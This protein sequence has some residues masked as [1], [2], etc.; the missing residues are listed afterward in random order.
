VT[1]QS[2]GKILVGGAFTS[3]NG[4]T[5]NRLVRLNSDGTLDTS[6]YTNLGTSFGNNVCSIAV[7][8]DGK[9]L[10]GGQFTTLNGATRNRLVRLNSDGTEDTSFYTNLGTGLNNDVYAITV[11]PDGKILVGGQ[12][13]TLN[14]T[15]RN[16]FVRLNSDGTVDTSFYTN[17]GT[18]FSSSTQYIASI[19]CLP[20]NKILIGGEFSSFNSNIRYGLVRLNAD[21]TEDSTFFSN[22]SGTTTYS[23]QFNRQSIS[24][25][26]G[27]NSV[28]G[29]YLKPNGDLIL[30][31][32]FRTYKN[33]PRSSIIIIGGG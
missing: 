23:R 30:A 14:S 8:S 5:R 19:V 29:M 22:S 12:F 10:V 11:Q 33:S 15:T 13:T 17:L 1:L 2:D 25:G 31:G 16:R 21:G 6:F 4:T 26:D 28:R 27:L 32:R 20:N 18:A 24:S 7:Q 3:L 9:I